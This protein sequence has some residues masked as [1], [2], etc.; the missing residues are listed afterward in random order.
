MS[1]KSE[2]PVCLWCNGR[3]EIK[4]SDFNVIVFGGNYCRCPHCKGTGIEPVSDTL[5]TEQVESELGAHPVL[6]KI[7]ELERENAKL[8][9]GISVS[10]SRLS[11]ACVAIIWLAGQ[12]ARH[13]P[14][15]Q[16]E[17]VNKIEEWEKEHEKTPDK[18]QILTRQ[19][20][21]LSAVCAAK[22][23]AL[24]RFAAAK[25][26]KVLNGAS[27][28][29]TTQELPEEI[30]IEALS[31][32]P[33]NALDPIREALDAASEL[34]E[35]HVGSQEKKNNSPSAQDVVWINYEDHMR[36]LGLIRE[37]LKTFGE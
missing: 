33:G 24:K 5:T 30:A 4:G 21:E 35:F 1:D 27:C 16:E 34:A 32:T 36:V 25:S 8:R 19:N 18:I 13:A 6:G 15:R 17:V 3:K 26:W 10:D 28:W 7:R 12:V 23:A 20:V 2:T 11:K 37:A 14:E 29:Y 22:D 9:T 31:L